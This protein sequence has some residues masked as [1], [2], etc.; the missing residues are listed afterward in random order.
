MDTVY[1]RHPSSSGL[2]PLL[3]IV[4][5]ND[6]FYFIEIC[7]LVN[8][9]HDNTLTITKKT[10]RFVLSALKKDAENDMSLF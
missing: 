7:D 6:I 10:I 1:K 5:M 9:A 8:Y 3:V 2:G 4:F